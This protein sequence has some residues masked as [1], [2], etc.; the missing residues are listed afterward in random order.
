ML[1]L[2]TSEP[3]SYK[4][5]SVGG[6]LMNSKVGMLHKD[7][8]V[9]LSNETCNNLDDADQ[10]AARQSTFQIVFLG[11]PILC[12]SDKGHQLR[13]FMRQTLKFD[14]NKNLLVQCLGNVT[15]YNWTKE[16]LEEKKI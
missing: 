12:D 15:F 3:L 4:R 16:V 14:P 10:H 1:I 7:I 8:A 11:T 5:C 9:E 13:G 6:Y 2:P